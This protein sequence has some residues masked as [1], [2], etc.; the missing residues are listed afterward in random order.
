MN[1]KMKELKDLKTSNNKKLLTVLPIN[2]VNEML[3]SECA[4][5][6]AQQ[7][8][9]T[10]L[11]ILTNEIN[12]KGLEVIKKIFDNPTIKIKKKNE[13]GTESE[14]VR[15][16]ENK[17]SYVIEQTEKETFFEVFNEAFNYAITNKYEWVSPIEYEDVLDFKW[18]K[19]FLTYSEEKKEIGGFLPI[20]REI[21][22]GVFIG[23]F[24]EASWGEGMA[25]VAGFF[26]LQLL[27]KFNCM[28]LTGG[29]FNVEMLKE[30]SEEKN[31]YFKPVK[32][33]MMVSSIYE[34]FLRMIY[35]D[36]KFYTIP[37]IGYERRIGIVEEVNKLSYKIPQNLVTIPEDKGGMNEEELRFWLDLAKKEYFFDE[38][39]NNE[40]KVPEISTEKNTE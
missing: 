28:N 5:S 11:L 26:D 9:S 33:S 3:L 35:N 18:Y 17:I 10:D 39:R 36:I 25:E 13:D 34:F 14:E 40:Y 38:D 1:I 23:L 8:F 24:N 7:E 29:I 20:T 27:L 6:I 4:Y 16:A 30:Y 2:R 21:K 37:R 22:N 31:N 32:E 15:G 12:E 19:N